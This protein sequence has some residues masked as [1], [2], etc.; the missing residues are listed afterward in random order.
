MAEIKYN[1]IQVFNIDEF[2]ATELSSKSYEVTIAGIGLKSILVT[3]QF[4]YS[5][6]YEDTQLVVNFGGEN[7]FVFNGYALYLDEKNNVHLGLP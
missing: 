7:P 1:W 6:I 2:D 3:K 5:V 4:G